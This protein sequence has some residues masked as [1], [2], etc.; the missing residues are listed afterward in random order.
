MGGGVRPLLLDLF[1]GAGGAATGYHRAGFEVVGV[2]IKPQPRY[3]FQF[4]QADAITLLD[5]LIEDRPLVL[6][7]DDEIFPVDA[8]HASP[9]C[10]DHMRSP[11]HNQD[12]HGTG[13]ML[14]ATRDRLAQ[15]GVPW[16]IENVPGAPIRPDYMLCG[17]MFPELRVRSERLFETSWHAFELVPAHDH[18]RE[19]LNRFRTM[20]G[21]YFR[22]NGHVPTRRE[23]AMAMGIDWMSGSEHQQAIPPA[24]T[25][26]IG[27]QLLEHLAVTRA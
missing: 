25:E 24:Y 23:V 2:D 3:P 19:V 5:E 22:R 15:S 18:S 11:T 14:A 17:C 12:A 9:P 20:H 7:F 8:I 21:P 16:V 4:V 6:Y 27:L 1:C 13:W 26:R 10:Q